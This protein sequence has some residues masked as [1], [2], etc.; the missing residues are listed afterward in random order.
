[1]Q[2]LLVSAQDKSGQ[3]T[4]LIGQVALD[5]HYNDVKAHSPPGHL[6]YPA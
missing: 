3:I 4:E 1:M 5:G 2:S 6:I